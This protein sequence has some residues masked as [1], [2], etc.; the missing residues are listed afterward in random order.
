MTIAGPAPT[1]LHVLFSSVITDFTAKRGLEARQVKPLAGPERRYDRFLVAWRL[2]KQ[3]LHLIDPS[4]VH[5]RGPHFTTNAGPLRRHLA[6]T[7][8]PLAPTDKEGSSCPQN[9][10][11]RDILTMQSQGARAK[12]SIA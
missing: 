7:K 3:L 5:K 6:A 9:L 10:V 2:V 1:H 12:Q 11:M 8:L 4:F